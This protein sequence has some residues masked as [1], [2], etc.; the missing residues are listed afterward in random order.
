MMDVSR[1]QY[2]LMGTVLLL[3]GVQF[4]LTDTFVLNPHAT[5]FLAEQ[6]DHPVASVYAATETLAPEAEP[7]ITKTVKPPDYVG[8][9]FTSLGVVLILHSWGMKK[10]D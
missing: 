10:S 9:L 3:L 8:Y 5:A 6:T 2:F 1:N 7:T 4:L